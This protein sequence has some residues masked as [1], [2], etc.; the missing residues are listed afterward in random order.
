MGRSVYNELKPPTRS[1]RELIALSALDNAVKNE[2]VPERLRFKDKDILIQAFFDMQDLPD[3]EGHRLARPLRRDLTEPTIWVKSDHTPKILV[4][5]RTLNG[6]MGQ[7]R[8]DFLG[9]RE[10]IYLT[11]SDEN[12]LKMMITDSI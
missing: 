3:L 8:H 6:G 7:D 11:R 5:L 4:M 1:V 12:I 9:L 10:K 2:N